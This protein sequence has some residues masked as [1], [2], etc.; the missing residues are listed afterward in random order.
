M[1]LFLR[2]NQKSLLVRTAVGLRQTSV[3]WKRAA[4][5]LR[6]ECNPEWLTQTSEATK[7]ADSAPP[8]S[9][10][11]KRWKCGEVNTERRKNGNPKNVSLSTRLDE[12]LPGLRGAEES[13][14]LQYREKLKWGF[15]FYFFVQ[16]ETVK[17]PPWVINRASVGRCWLSIDSQ[18]SHL[19]LGVIWIP[20]ILIYHVGFYTFQ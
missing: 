3:S 15:F 7:A 12:T 10:T 5:R 17:C 20:I 13:C 14:D 18:A 19:W 9:R 6:G 2:K 1:V 16:T 11:G 4:G 8:E